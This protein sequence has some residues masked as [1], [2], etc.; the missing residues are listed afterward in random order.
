MSAPTLSFV[1]PMPANLA[2]ARMHWAVK[3]LKRRAYFEACDNLQLRGEVPPPPLKPFPKVVANE[4]MYLGAAMDDDNA[5]ARTKWI[6]DWLKT[7][8]YIADDRKA[9]IIR[10]GYPKQRVKRDG[11]YRVEVT[12]TALEKCK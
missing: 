8:G 1:L 3:D 10:Q 4:V 7:R 9:N 12:L 6:W 2:N 11:N 5:A